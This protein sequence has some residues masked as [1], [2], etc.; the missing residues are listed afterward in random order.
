MKSLSST[1]AVIDWLELELGKEL[2]AQVVEQVHRR[3]LA[4]PGR[5]THFATLGELRRE[6]LGS[7]TLPSTAGCIAALAPCFASH[8]SIPPPHV[9]LGRGDTAHLTF[10]DSRW[11]PPVTSHCTPSG[12]PGLSLG[13]L[14]GRSIDEPGRAQEA[15]NPALSSAGACAGASAEEPAVGGITLTGFITAQASP[16]KFFLDTATH[17]RKDQRGGCLPGSLA[18]SLET[19][20]GVAKRLSLQLESEQARSPPLNSPDVTTDQSGGE[21]WHRPQGAPPPQS[22]HSAAV[23]ALLQAASQAGSEPEPALRN[24]S[25]DQSHGALGP[26]VAPTPTRSAR[27]PLVAKLDFKSLGMSRA[28]DFGWANGMEG[29][30][31]VWY[32]DVVIHDKLMERTLQGLT[33]DNQSGRIASTRNSEVVHGCWIPCGRRAAVTGTPIPV[34]AKILN[35]ST[36]RVCAAVSEVRV[37]K[38]LEGCS[39]AV[40]LL[41]YG[42]HQGEVV[43]LLEPC[44]A[45]LEGWRKRQTRTPQQCI[46]MALGSAE[47]VA[48]LHERGVAH[49]DVKPRNVLLA[50]D[51]TLKLADFGDALLLDLSDHITSIRGTEGYQCCEM[52]AASPTAT[53]DARRADVWSLGCL[54]FELV[55]GQMLFHSE[56][57]TLPV[58]HH[59]RACSTEQP[60]LASQQSAPSH[61]LPQHETA[62]SK[63][64]ALVAAAAA[65]AAPAAP[66]QT[67]LEN[68]RQ[69]IAIQQEDV[70]ASE[71]Q[72]SAHQGVSRGKHVHA[73]SLSSQQAR[74]M[75][76]QQQRSGAQPHSCAAVPGQQQVNGDPCVDSTPLTITAASKRALKHSSSCS[77]CS[78]E[79]VGDTSSTHT[80][81]PQWGCGSGAQ[82]ACGPGAPPPFGPEPAVARHRPWWMTAAQLATL[83]ASLLQ[84][85]EPGPAA[86][87]LAGPQAGLPTASQPPRQGTPLPTGEAL[88]LGVLQLL[89][90]VI[91]PQADRPG[92]SWVVAQL[93][94]L[95]QGAPAP[96]HSCDVL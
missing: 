70:F 49:L 89:G 20:S 88:L 59:S 29:S 48:M 26:A 10:R 24:P 94:S 34:V 3:L 12:L 2:D 16:E 18:G 80:H 73:R 8:G 28:I 5:A 86:A 60:T 77:S 58:L 90:Q 79:S 74:S 22:T 32:E 41:K 81:T 96:P 19:L 61:P 30:D 6:L 54:L 17:A 7:S 44:Q 39:A 55:T 76:V 33:T 15:L 65:A 9:R 23:A 64:V 31:D 62:A 46:R 56:L 14:P 66:S 91:V 4:T 92:A 35:L 13:R 27:R 25:F 84:A 11:Q 36:M 71:P 78:R 42:V 40:G 95:L 72:R 69:L 37:M 21:D 57:E 87:G 51:G 52:L 53:V 67:V 45:D 82:P 38:H 93:R 83:R 47:L 85:P 50:Q 63:A 75:R 43:M 68:A 1:G